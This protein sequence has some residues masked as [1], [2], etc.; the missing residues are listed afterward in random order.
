MKTIVLDTNCL[1][2]CLA[3]KNKYHG[4]WTAF[5]NEDFQICVSND[6][7]NEYEEILAKKISPSFADMIIQ[8]IMNSENVVFVHPTFKFNLITADPDDNKFVDCAI[9]ANAD[10]I[11]SEDTHFDILKK[12]D[13]PK[14]NVIRI[15]EFIKELN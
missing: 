11:V 4:V 10:Y 14:V 7:I 9:V 5:L 6:I 13:F 8:I 1:L 12:I 15:E 2:V 3:T